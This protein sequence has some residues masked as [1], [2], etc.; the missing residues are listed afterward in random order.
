M[1]IPEVSGVQSAEASKL[2]DLLNQYKSLKGEKVEAESSFELRYKDTLTS[3]KMRSL[4]QGGPPSKEEEVS[5]GRKIFNTVANI[6]NTVVNFVGD[7]LGFTSQENSKL[8]PIN[9]SHLK[10]LIHEMNIA[11]A[12]MQESTNDADEILI[13]KDADVMMMM[14]LKKTG[15]QQ[16]ELAREELTDRTR[17]QAEIQ[18]R[19][20]AAIDVINRIR[21]ELTGKSDTSKILGYVN[22]ALTA[23]V[24][25][26]STVLL[27]ASIPATGGLT[28][29]AATSIGVIT[30]AAGAFE[31]GGIIAKAFIDFEAQKQRATVESIST[32]RQITGGKSESN[33]NSIEKMISVIHQNNTLIIEALAMIRDTIRYAQQG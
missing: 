28:A 32:D 23:L 4:D 6:F 5:W 10:K 26:G 18:D 7:L 12:K 8:Q 21:G 3:V 16:N 13:Q 17:Y 1:S 31:G 9:S 15:L 11:L 25:G 2:N 19:N 20:R 29:A 24:I 33:L 30:A 27:I 14:I 22:G